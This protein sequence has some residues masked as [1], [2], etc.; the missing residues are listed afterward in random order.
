MRHLSVS[1]EIRS[2][3]GWET[4]WDNP[5]EANTEI[6]KLKAEITQAIAD[7]CGID[8]DCIE[9]KSINMEP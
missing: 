6:S 2:I 1:I 3:D 7:H 8:H 9:V 5:P 4:N